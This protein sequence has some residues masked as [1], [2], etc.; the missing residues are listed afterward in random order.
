MASR[1][2]PLNFQPLSGMDAGFLYMETPTLHMHT[3]KVAIMRPAKGVPTLKFETFRRAFERRIERLPSFRQRIMDVPFGLGHPV[4]VADRSFD[5]SRHLSYRTASAPGGMKELNAIVSEVAS[6][7][8]LRDR[9][10]WEITMV[11]GL[12]GER[13]AFVCKLHHAMADGAAAMAM[14]LEV[15]AQP[16]RREDASTRDG[17]ISAANSPSDSPA[18]TEWAVRR[19]AI[20]QTLRRL[21]SLPKLLFL[22]L[23]GIF[24]LAKRAVG[25]THPHLPAPFSGPRISWSGA[26]SARRSFATTLVPLDDM[27]RVKVALGVTLNDVFLAVCGGALRAHLEE[28]EGRVPS[29]ALLASVPVNTDPGG[30]GRTRGNRVGHLSVSLCTDIPDA[31]ER[32]RAIHEM[33]DE[34][35]QRQ[36]ALGPDLL[37]RWVEYV[38][39]EPY[40][41]FIRFWSGRDMA[42]RVHPPVNLIVSNVPGSRDTLEIGGHTLEALYSVGPILEG[43]GLNFTGWSYGDRVC[44]VG[45]A[46]PDQIH[47]I[48]GLVDRLPHALEE[49][50]DACPTERGSSA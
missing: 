15:V 1:P 33:T 30:S 19:W 26:L 21:A 11:D 50:L 23:R 47:D 49:L 24:N 9:P 5:P 45:L 40:M 6:R 25:G 2:K 12:E 10:L 17:A 7:P 8:L 29:E 42:D 18:P 27:K 37:E 28:I 22:T 34:A 35:K 20:G 48:Q 31:V 13:T 43:I 44:F 41:A 39:P 4:W 36:L 38:P 46:C 16:G 14:L 32:V 3:L